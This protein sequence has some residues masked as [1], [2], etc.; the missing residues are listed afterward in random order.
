ML[1]AN[2]RFF[3][4]AACLNSVP[5]H[6]KHFYL[7]TLHILEPEMHYI[8]CAIT[9]QSL[10]TREVKMTFTRFSNVK[11]I[12]D[13]VSGILNWIC[14]ECGGRMGGRGKE[15]KCQGECQ[16]DWRLIWERVVAVRR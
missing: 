9:E 4:D 5:F 15:F 8:R 6:P 11:T 10:E 14:P 16:T 1:L 12:T 13:V 2:C 7:L 3:Y